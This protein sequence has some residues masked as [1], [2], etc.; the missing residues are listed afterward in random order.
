M[1]VQR[2]EKELRSYFVWSSFLP[3]DNVEA[4]R[5]ATARYSAP[6]SVFFW[7]PDSRLP[8]DLAVTL[9][10]PV[11]RPAWKVYLLYGR[12]TIW[13]RLPP[14]PAY[15]QQQ[16]DVLQG[17]KFDIVSLEVEIQRALRK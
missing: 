11:G 3:T 12:G 10:L 15:W 7:A 2:Q 4:A 16:L 6:D 13:D 17:D 1:L 14:K 8:A 9:R 5:S